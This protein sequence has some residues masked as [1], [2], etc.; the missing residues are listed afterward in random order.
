MSEGKTLIVDVPSS[1]Q[2]KRIKLDRVKS[3]VRVS[4]STGDEPFQQ[5]FRVDTQVPVRWITPISRK[6]PDSSEM[7]RPDVG[8]PV[9]IYRFILSY[10]LD[11]L[12]KLVEE[13]AT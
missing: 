1:K 4:W 9:W 10:E 13:K 2:K 6:Y 8:I 5:A 3:G 11:D 7:R 12:V